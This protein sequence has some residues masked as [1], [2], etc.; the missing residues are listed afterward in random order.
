[1]T[2]RCIRRPRHRIVQVS[3][4]SSE[5][6]DWR[7]TLVGEFNY[8]NAK[9]FFP[10]RAITD[11]RFKLIHN[12]IAGETA[13]SSGTG[14]DN[15]WTLAQALPEDD[16][17]RTAM[18]RLVDPPEWELYDLENDPVEFHNRAGEATLHDVE[19]RLRAELAEWQKATGDRFG[20][21][22]FRREIVAEHGPVER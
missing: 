12:L 10:R 18:N 2:D 15:A 1:M 11:G 19:S 17:A 16:P 5:D 21:P 6:V 20:D 8:H 7:N 14:G 3:L 13:A 9:T 4:R 22:G